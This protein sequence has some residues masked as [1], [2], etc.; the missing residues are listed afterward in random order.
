MWSQFLNSVHVMQ[1][2]LILM[3]ASPPDVTKS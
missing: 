1:E 2:Q 3:V